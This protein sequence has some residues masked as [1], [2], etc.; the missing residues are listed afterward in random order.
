MREIVSVQAGQCGNQIGARFWQ[1]LCSEHSIDP[2]GDYTGS[3][4]EELERINVYFTE[5]DAGRYVPRSVLVDLEPGV[6]DTIQATPYGDLF[7][8]D[9]FVFGASGAGNN[10]FLFSFLVVFFFSL[11]FAPPPPQNDS[12][13]LLLLFFYFLFLFS[14]L[15]YFLLCDHFHWN[16]EI[17]FFLS[18]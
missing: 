12:P 16:L 8:P 10:W 7:R 2:K 3:K 14:F 4:A 6:I 18:Y 17:A 11:S 13:N 1:T 15:S 5:A 9:N